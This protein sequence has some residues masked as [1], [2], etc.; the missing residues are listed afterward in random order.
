MPKDSSVAAR[1]IKFCNTLIHRQKYS[2]GIIR[3]QSN[4]NW[5]EDFGRRRMELTSRDTDVYC[6]LASS[7]RGF[8]NIIK[9]HLKFSPSSQITS[10]NLFVNRCVAWDIRVI[11]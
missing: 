6:V 11:S 10:R 7:I 8:S 3:S 4:S 2:L 9:K 5:R 1:A